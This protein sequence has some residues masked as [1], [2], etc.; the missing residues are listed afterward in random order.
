M[1]P[2]I[3]IREETGAD[4]TA[5]RAVNE[6]A[7]GGRVEAA[8]VDELRRSGGV[9]LSLVAE[10]D[11][12][13]IGHILFSPVSISTAPGLSSVVGLAPMAVLPERQGQGVGSML[14]GEGLQTLRARGHSAVVVL[15]HPRYY[16]R[17]GFVP[18]TR[19]GLRC[20]FECPD[21][22]FLALELTPGALAGAAGGVVHY[23]PEFGVV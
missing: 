5:I 12:S 13:I 17:F 14:V 9:T 4:A 11:G 20:E 16:P 18:A 8:I 1:Q 10:K 23:R 22:A 3:S 2:D 6:R 15:G 7:F 19:F 21:D